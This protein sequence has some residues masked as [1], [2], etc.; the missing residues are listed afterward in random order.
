MLDRMRR[1]VERGHTVEPIMTWSGIASAARARMVDTAVV[2]VAA[3]DG[4]PCLADDGTPADAMRALVEEGIPSLVYTTL[5]AE[6]AGHLRTVAECGV[7]HVM[8]R[9]I[10]DQPGRFRD[11][12]EAIRL[13]GLENR[14][15]APLLE[16]LTA[17]STPTSV[18]TGFRALFQTPDRFRTVD[19]LALASGYTR[20]Y[21]NR[22]LEEAALASSKT[23][24]HAAYALRAYQFARHP[25]ATAAQ[26]GERL[27]Y[28][29][30]ATFR[31]QLRQITG[32]PYTQWRDQTP[33]QCVAAIRG[34]LGLTG[35]WNARALA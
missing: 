1:V 11:R 35:H 24:V 30:T 19:D 5:T 13:D 4:V 15:L 20:S 10:D 32:L 28:T 6:T 22:L 18:L 21:I 29:N 12:L 8:F 17:R 34:R 23:V 9:G 31:R 16:T 27:R 14:V 3:P 33:E 26:V 25:G 7:R 2:D